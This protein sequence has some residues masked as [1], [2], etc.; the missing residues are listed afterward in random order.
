MVRSLLAFGLSGLVLVLAL[1]FVIYAGALG[2]RGLMEDMTGV[3]RLFQ[4]Q[5]AVSNMAMALHMTFG[6]VI[7][8][9][10][11]LQVLGP[12]RRRFPRLHRVVGRVFV[13]LALIT[14]ICGCF[15]IAMRGTIGGA[16]MDGAFALYGL[17]VIVCA[18]QTFRRARQGDFARHREWALRLAVLALAS[19]FYRL[20]YAIW[21][22]ATGGIARSDDFTG[23]FDRVQLLAFFVPYLILLEGLFVIERRRVAGPA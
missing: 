22:L 2:L 20:H 23:A 4:P 15:Y 9:L 6:A 10:A 1:P 12:I 21:E 17:C 16:A 13:V 3:S 5:A 7:T 11:P 18:V 14:G 8:V 19:W